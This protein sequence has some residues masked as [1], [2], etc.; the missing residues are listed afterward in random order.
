MTDPNPAV[1]PNWEGG[2]R[3]PVILAGGGG[4]EGRESLNRAPP[5]AFSKGPFG[6]PNFWGQL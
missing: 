2:K 6:N 3:A 1:Y 4:L 5:G